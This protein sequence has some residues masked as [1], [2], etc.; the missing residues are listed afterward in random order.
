MYTDYFTRQVRRLRGLINC[1][2]ASSKFTSARTT[3]PMSIVKQGKLKDGD[4]L[5]W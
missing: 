5:D 3:N 1:G 2:L 4:K